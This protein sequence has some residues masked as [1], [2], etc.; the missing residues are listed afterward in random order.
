MPPKSQLTA[1]RAQVD[2]G[3]P[4]GDRTHN[5]R[6]KRTEAAVP[7]VR[8]WTSGDRFCWSGRVRCPVVHRLVSIRGDACVHTAFT[9]RS[10]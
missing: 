7:L 8:G 10:D 3:G 2:A 4:R 9:V 6:I 1:T 5:P